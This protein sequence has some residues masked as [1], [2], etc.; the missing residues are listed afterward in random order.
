MDKHREDF[1][2]HSIKRKV[3]VIIVL[4]LQARLYEEYSKIKLLRGAEYM[5]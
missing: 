3:P 4:G 2:R 5:I 1:E